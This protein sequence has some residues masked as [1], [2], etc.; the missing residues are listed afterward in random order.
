[1]PSLHFT[2]VYTTICYFRCKVLFGTL[3][4]MLVSPAL[5]FSLLPL[6]DHA[7]IIGDTSHVRLGL[8]TFRRRQWN[9]QKR[10]NIYCSRYRMAYIHSKNLIC[11]FS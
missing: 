8:D 9:C 5:L 10:L 1:M 11:T 3:S 4:I 6:P 2:S 7:I